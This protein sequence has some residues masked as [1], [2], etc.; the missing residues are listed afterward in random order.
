MVRELLSPAGNF[1]SLK[2]AV[3]SGADAVYL[4]GKRFGA[5]AFAANFSDEEIINAIS[6]CHLYGVRI[7]VTINTMIYESELEDVLSYILFLYQNHVDAII[8]SD[9][10]LMKIC[11]ERF[12]DLEIHAS[13]QTH[14]HNVEQMKLLK[15][16]GVKRAVLAREL[17]LEE[18]KKF[19]KDLELE[20]FIHGALCVSYS[21]QCL[22]SSF[23]LQRS[24]NRGECAQICRLPFHLLKNGK[25]VET[26]G[27]YL[28]SLK[29]LNT[30][31]RFLELL[32]API[33][34]FKIEGRMKSPSY[35]GFITKM[36]RDLMQQYEQT[37]T[38]HVT[39]EIIKK[40]SV[41]FGRGFTEG[42]LFSKMGFD[43][44]NQKTSNH[45]GIDLGDVLEIKKHKIKILLKEDL[46]QG[47]GI[48]FLEDE[49][50][51]NV[52][53]LY[54]AKGLLISSAKA[55]E[56][57]YLDNKIG[58]SK[59]KTIRKTL[60]TVLEQEIKSMPIQK[61]PVSMR[62]NVSLQEGFQLYL[63]DY[64]H[65]VFIQ[66][67]IVYPAKS[68]PISQD[69]IVMQLSKLGSTPFLVKEIDV[70][71]DDNVFVNI[72][73]INDIRRKAVMLLQDKRIQRMNAVV[74]KEPDRISH[75]FESKLCISVLVRN[76]E[77]LNCVLPY[78][79]VI[80]VEDY[81]LYQK[82]RSEKVFFRANRVEHHIKTY[83]VSNVLIGEFGSLERYS[84]CSKIIDYFLNVSNH[85]TADLFIL[86][87][88]QKICLSP[89]LSKNEVKHLL[90]EYPKG[91]NF[92]VI[93]YG[94]LE[95]MVLNHCILNTNVNRDKKCSACH[96][97]DNFALMD[98]NQSVYPLLFDEN[99]RT[100]VFYHQAVNH[101]PE[102][103]F[104]YK[105]GIRSFRFD[106]F[107]ETSKE[108][109]QIIQNF[110]KTLQE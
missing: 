72:K 61:I 49:K 91:N 77:Q 50:G 85:A 86:K 42:K 27:N 29:D 23:L 46:H 47:D 5:R 13:T 8:V 96:R 65:E 43:F 62:V 76:E 97:D 52:N 108:I 3:F 104:Y 51:M 38:C 4:G 26:K 103:N 100:H 93:I 6:F 107:N 39:N 84:N 45:Q 10:G 59:S 83:D 79:D 54:D 31:P 36:Y 56:I 98:R 33:T 110:K 92:E 60:D 74:L 58:I 41:L 55:G 40:A 12:P 22:F 106:F 53:F 87:G 19:P 2:M 69:K 109:V 57:I 18:I 7:Y 68:A 17:T 90:S 89:E 75:C 14:I 73:D 99:H 11:H 21:G 66:E 81:E 63:S 9:L 24:G 64:H 95:V 67:K 105:I 1:E 78:A 80:Y 16:L 25:K 15:S 101:I 70:T 88:A 82:Y 94:R 44:V 32:S 20:V 102:V 35:V 71:L 28:L 48:R 37:G 34:S 30:A